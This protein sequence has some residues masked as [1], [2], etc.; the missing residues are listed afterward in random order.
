[1]KKT[2]EGGVEDWSFIRKSHVLIYT[3]MLFFLLPHCSHLLLQFLPTLTPQGVSEDVGIGYIIALKDKAACNMD[4][5]RYQF[6]KA[7]G[8]KFDFQN[9]RKKFE[10]I[11]AE[12]DKSD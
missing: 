10:D 1:M 3:H 2:R 7:Q 9:V 4:H 8:P 6:K 5:E 12:I 11:C